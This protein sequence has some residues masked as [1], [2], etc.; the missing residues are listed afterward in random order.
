MKS[1][2]VAESNVETEALSVL[3]LLCTVIIQ[4]QERM[5]TSASLFMGICVWLGGYVNMDIECG[6]WCV[7][8]W[9]WSIRHDSWCHSCDSASEQ[10]RDRNKQT[11]S[12]E[13]KKG[14]TLKTDRATEQK[15]IE[16]SR[17]IAYHIAS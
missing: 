3:S 5:K 14:G 15:P 10:P 1:K 16:N 12:R 6:P 7:C 9:S 4:S 11:T 13:N 2:N 17:N 8:V